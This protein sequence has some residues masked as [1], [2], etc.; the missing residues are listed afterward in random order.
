MKK[1]LSVLAVLCAL[2]LIACD[3]VATFDKPQPDDVKPLASLPARLQGRYMAKDRASVVTI[4]KKLISRHYDFYVIEHRDSLI[5]YYRLSGDSL[6]DL[7]TGSVEMVE[8][9]G[10]SVVQHITWIDTLFNLMGGDVLKKIK[11]HYFLNL[12]YRGNAWIVNKLSLQNGKLTIGEIS[13]TEEIKTLREI[14]ESTSDTVTTHFSPTLRQFRT[15]VKKDGFSDQETFT[16]M[17]KRPFSR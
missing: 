17:S 15:F 2:L 16:R 1:L 6:I 7:N 13:G 5:P 10:D 3:P 4:H 8:I 9:R 11:G 12:Q 14:T